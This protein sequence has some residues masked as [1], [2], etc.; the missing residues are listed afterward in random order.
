MLLRIIYCMH[1]F[2]SIKSFTKYTSKNNY[3][4]M[5]LFDIK[6]T[7]SPNPT[8]NPSTKSISPLDPEYVTVDPSTVPSCYHLMI[9]GVIPRPVAFV[10]TI[11]TIT[12]IANIA[13]YSYFNMMSHAPP[14]VAIGI[15][16][17]AGGIKKDTLVNIEDNG[18]FVVNIISN[19][20]VEAA[21]YCAG[22]FPA[23]VDEM[24]VTNLTKIPSDTIKP[25]R[26]QES[27]FQMECKIIS[28]VEIRNKLG[29]H[30][31]TTVLGEVIRIH[32]SKDLYE[33]N[34][35]NGNPQVNN[36]KYG[37]LGRLGGDTWL[38]PGST[39]DIPRPKV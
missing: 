1:I 8:W 27:A 5:S 14:T 18:E 2:T 30:T 35:K 22:D 26:I 37:Y 34:E 31:S 15:C 23:N 32:I 3:S 29:V 16:N 33:I 19:W 6:K 11:N 13:P 36:D 38:V 4:I 20:F 39:F 7:S 24:E 17:K 21:S 10:S 28:K 9:S 25:C 12:G